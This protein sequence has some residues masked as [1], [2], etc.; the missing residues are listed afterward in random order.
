MQDRLEHIRQR[1][2]KAK[3]YYGWYNPSAQFM[4]EIEDAEED[5]RWLLYEVE[6]LRGLLS[7]PPP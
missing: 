1:L 7:P 5:V 2:E 6:R 4:Y 3:V